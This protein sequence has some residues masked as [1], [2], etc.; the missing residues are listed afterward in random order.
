MA[1]LTTTPTDIDN[2]VKGAFAG[3][4]AVEDSENIMDYWRLLSKVPQGKG[5]RPYLHPHKEA[6]D[7]TLQDLEW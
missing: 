6:G 4:D 3:V 1:T 7:V 5:L 2:A